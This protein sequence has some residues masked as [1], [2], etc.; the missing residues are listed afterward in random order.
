MSNLLAKHGIS[1]E[2]EKEMWERQNLADLLFH[3]DLP[4]TK[5]IQMLE[6][7]EELAKSM[8]GGKLPKSPE[9]VEIE[10]LLARFL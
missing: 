3:A 1:A 10:K 6:G 7:M 2:R 9:D 5:K 4:L 8:H